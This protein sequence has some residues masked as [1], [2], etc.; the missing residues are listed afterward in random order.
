MPE[1]KEVIEERRISQFSRTRGQR[2]YENP[3]TGDVAFD[4]KYGKKIFLDT[5]EPVSIP[6]SSGDS[7]YV[8]KVAEEGRLDLISMEAYGTPN[9]DWVIAMVNDL[10]DMVQSVTAG[11]LL[12]IPSEEAIVARLK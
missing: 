4:N 9:Y 2:V 6:E 11:K 12:R 3:I 5:W 7:L 1:L 8:V 10:P